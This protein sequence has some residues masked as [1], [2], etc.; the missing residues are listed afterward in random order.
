MFVVGQSRFTF[1]VTKN[2]DQNKKKV[3]NQHDFQSRQKQNEEA[4]S[5][6]KIDLK[7]EGTRQEST[8]TTKKDPHEWI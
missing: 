8:V 6:P 1:K 7:G 5:N 4:K 2:Q 3:S